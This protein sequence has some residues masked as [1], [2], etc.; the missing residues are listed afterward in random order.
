[1]TRQPWLRP[2]LFLT[3]LAILAGL[4]GRCLTIV[5]ATQFALVTEFGRPLQV[6]GDDPAEAGPHWIAPWQSVLRVDR[7]IQF[8]DS[9]P[10]ELLSAD[11][12]DLEIWPFFAWR[13]I[14]PTRFL[15]AAGTLQA[16][17]ARLDER[18]AA[19]LAAAVA[20]TPF[21]TPSLTPDDAPIDP[22]SDQLPSILDELNRAAT[23]ELGVELVDLGLRRIS[24]PLEV[25]PAIFELIRS[26]RRQAAES[27]RAAAEA[28]YQSRVS[29]AERDRRIT[30][31][32]A[33]AQARQIEAAAEA[34]ALALL[35]SAHAENPDLY[36]FLQTLET[37][38]S[39]LNGQATLVLSTSSPLFRLLREGPDAPP[40]PP[41]SEADRAARLSPPASRTTP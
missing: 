37:Y 1:M 40:P 31:A 26:E 10:R 35:N 17:E 14:D 41:A 3:V 5:D 4:A 38:R 6:L 12:K 8:A 21:A 19:A 36:S 27:I 9:A 7:R 25:R 11:K 39:L 13:V 16:A 33:E 32:Q 28:E 24:Y 30:L 15:R 23:A 22:L 34:E 2:V 29:H 18:L 20:Q